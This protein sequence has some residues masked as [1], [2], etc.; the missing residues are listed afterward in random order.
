MTQWSKIYTD[1]YLSGTDGFNFFTIERPYGLF[2]D[3]TKEQEFV[4]ALLPNR[5]RRIVNGIE[6]PMTSSGAVREY[7]ANSTRSTHAFAYGDRNGE[8]V[9]YIGTR[10]SRDLFKLLLKFPNADN[11]K[12]WPSTMLFTVRVAEGDE[13]VPNGKGMYGPRSQFE[14]LL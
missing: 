12:T 13:F 8:G 14:D 6:I 7:L 10:S 1:V 9:F 5:K 11:I 4:D 3:G 2:D